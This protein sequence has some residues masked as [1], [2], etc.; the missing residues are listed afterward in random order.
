[1][2]SYFR[3][4]RQGQIASLHRRTAT[5]P[6]CHATPNLRRRSCHSESTPPHPARKGTRRYDRNPRVCVSSSLA[7]K[8]ITGNYQGSP[9]HS[10]RWAGHGRTEGRRRTVPLTSCPTPQIP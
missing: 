7:Y 5:P 10:S 3:Q 4:F 1:M 9:P 2:A 8:V 6:H